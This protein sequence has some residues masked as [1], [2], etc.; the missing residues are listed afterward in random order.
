VE[1]DNGDKFINFTSLL[2]FLLSISLAHIVHNTFLQDAAGRILLHN[3]R[4]WRFYFTT[5]RAQP[6]TLVSHQ[7]L[8]AALE[9][10]DEQEALNAMREHILVSRAL[11][12][13]LF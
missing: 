2:K 13:A 3:L 7:P 11:L 8:L 12:N 4:F 6:G 9:R 10:R 5:H 1:Y